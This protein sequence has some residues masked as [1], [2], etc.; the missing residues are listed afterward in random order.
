M[1]DLS[2]WLLSNAEGE[3]R[4][5]EKRLKDLVMFRSLENSHAQ[6]NQMYRNAEN[7]TTGC[8]VISND[9]TKIRVLDVPGFFGENIGG[10][11][12]GQTLGER[13]TASGLHIMRE[14][15]RIQAVLRLK[16]NHLF[17]STT[18]WS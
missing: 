16:A 7:P 13:A 15:L 14:I 3:E 1:S 17:H 18:W 12:G 11:G 6:V 5:V 8:Q 4:R 2:M 10:A 9:T